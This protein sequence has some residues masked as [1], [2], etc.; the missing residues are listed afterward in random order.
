M[1]RT[2]RLAPRANTQAAWSYVTAHP[3]C[4]P[5]TAALTAKLN[6]PLEIG[7]NAV[8]QALDENLI[9]VNSTGCRSRLW[10]AGIILTKLA[11][12]LQVG[13]WFVDPHR[14]GR[15]LARV[16]QVIPKPG[17]RVAFIL[18]DETG[19]GAWIASYQLGDRLEVG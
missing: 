16:F 5:L 7:V 15:R 2:T 8:L 11:K 10:P 13:D 12:D 1:S 19:H 4:T 9:R 14:S 6:R 18:N 3:G 17:C